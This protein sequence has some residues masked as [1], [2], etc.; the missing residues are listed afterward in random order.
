MLIHVSALTLQA[1]DLRSP[2]CIVGASDRGARTAWVLTDF[3][4][5]QESK[6][7]KNI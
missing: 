5:S 4:G 3:S 1:T 2:I 7:T 6:W